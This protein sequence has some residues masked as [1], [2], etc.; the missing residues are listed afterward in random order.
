MTFSLVGMCRRTG[1]FGAAVTTVVANI[2]TDLVY[3]VMDP[4]IRAIT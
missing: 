2:L 3:R 1:M 4:R